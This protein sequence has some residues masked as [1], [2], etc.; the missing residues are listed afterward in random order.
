MPINVFRLNKENSDANKEV[1][2]QSLHERGKRMMQDDNFTSEISSDEV[3]QSIPNETCIR[4][5]EA[6]L[7]IN[8]EV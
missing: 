7:K 2:N 4:C 8:G 5:S 3:S 1:Q 6:K